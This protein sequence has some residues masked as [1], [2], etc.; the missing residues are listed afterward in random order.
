[1]KNLEVFDRTKRAMVEQVEFILDNALGLS[2]E[3][4]DILKL[5]LSRLQ[6]ISKSDVG[7]K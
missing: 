1:M 5:T 2:Q 6:K 3:Q 4:K 7:V